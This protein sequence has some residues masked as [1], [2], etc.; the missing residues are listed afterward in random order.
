M[1]GSYL[2]LRHGLRTLSKNRGF[3]AVAVL[4]LMLGIGGTS[5][6]FSVVET[7]LLRPLPYPQPERL[8]TVWNSIPELGF[9]RLEVSEPELIDYSR[10]FTVFQDLAAI[11]PF[12]ANLAGGDE[13]ERIPAAQVSASFFRVLGVA[14][15]LGRG[16][17]GGEDRKGR[18][19]VAVLG[20]GL[21]RRRFGADPSLVGKAVTLNA[22]PYVVVGVAPRGFEFPER[23]QLWVPLPLDL[24]HLGER[25]AHSLDLI[26][27]LSPGV[28]LTQAQAQAAGMIHN[29]QAQSPKD[30]SARHPWS[31]KLVPLQEQLVGQARR[32]LLVLSAAVALV[33]LIACTNVANLILARTQARGGEITLRVALGAGRA[34]LVRQ[35]LMEAMLLALAGGALGLL[36]AR[37]GLAALLAISPAQVP[38]A[39]EI[40]LDW[41]IVLFAFAVSLLTGLL[42]S[43]VAAFPASRVQLAQALNQGGVRTGGGL[44]ARRFR[45]FLVVFEMAAA[46]VLLLA[47]GLVIK[48]FLALQRT[49][50]GFDPS[51][52]LTASIALPEARYGEGRPA[53]GAFYEALHERLARLPGVRSVGMAEHLPMGSTGLSGPFH[54][55]GRDAGRAGGLAPESDWN[56]A[57][58]EYFPTMRIPLLAGRN[59]TRFDRLGA[60]GV[61]IVDANVAHGVWP[62]EDPIGKR[63]RLAGGDQNPWLTVVGVVGHVRQGGLDA[64]TRGEVYMPQAQQLP[65]AMYVAVRAADPAA[66]APALRQAVRDVDR[67]QAVAEVLTMRERIAGSLAPRLFSTLLLAVFSLL[68]L[69][70]AAVGIYSVTAWAVAQRT[71]EIGIRVALGAE[72]AAVLRLVVGRGMRLVLIGLAIGWLVALA[73][74]HVVAAL[75]YQT[76]PRD[77]IVFAA[78]PLLLAGVALLANYL[79]A[80]RATAVDPAIALRD[81]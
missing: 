2:D 17:A 63:I 15:R 80:R 65:V 12:D 81:A 20:D 53:V 77:P 29:L 10:G 25:G 73:A 28:T 51:G 18:H 11:S 5:A 64:A 31:L 6:I 38:R 72:P 71:R 58:P 32:P 49:D 27:R 46:I 68:A 79:P 7:L 78:V 1:D 76:S 62:G 22:E 41:R 16:F 75:L 26:A 33:L 14:P 61:V 74:S 55:A 30:Y 21:W 23:T 3:A 35:F 50:P 66:L 69:A 43:L 19:R 52:L 48:N 54:V 57:N 8:V 42:L 67:D 47:A 13:P 34:R 39:A 36:L 70:L 37:W 45:G 59:F 24:A 60:P 9:D 44:G 40:D 4:T 56:W